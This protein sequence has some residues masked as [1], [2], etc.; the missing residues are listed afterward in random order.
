[1]L[2]AGDTVGPY[3][4]DALIG[5]GGMGQVYRA[6]DPRLDRTVALKVIVRGHPND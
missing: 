4:I 3:V 2:S 5:Q 1:M 6:H